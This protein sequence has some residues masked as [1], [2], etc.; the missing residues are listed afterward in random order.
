MH[1]HGD[2]AWPEVLRAHAGAKLAATWAEAL[3]SKVGTLTHLEQYTSAIE[4]FSRGWKA[5]WWSAGC[6]CWR[7]EVLS[8]KDLHAFEA[9]VP[10]HT[11]EEETW[12]LTIFME[13]SY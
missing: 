5:E 12:A 11:P 9:L 10:P 4:I 1:L 2:G 8:G 3:K 6:P 7:H 13:I